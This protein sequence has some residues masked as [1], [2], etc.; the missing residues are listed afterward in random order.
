M[1]PSPALEYTANVN[2]RSDWLENLGLEEPVDLESYRNVLHAFT[3]DDPDG[4][5]QDDTYGLT[6]R[7]DNLTTASEKA[8]QNIFGAYGIPKGR[9]IELEDGTVTTWVKHPRFLEAISYIRTL[10]NDGVVEPDY[11]AIP[12][13]DMFGKLWTGVAGCLEWEC[14][15]P[16]NNWM[17]SRYTEDPVPTI[18]VTN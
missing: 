12:Q 1:V 2:L 3:Y 8:F 13:M 10:I 15:G 6:F 11:V 9:E 14:V 16:T 4:D 18:V 17:P 7:L 5:G